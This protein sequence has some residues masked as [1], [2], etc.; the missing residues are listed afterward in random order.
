M[1]SFTSQLRSML[2]KGIMGH[3]I[4]WT[5]K[6]CRFIYNI[7]ISLQWARLEP[8][9]LIIAGT[10]CATRFS[11]IWWKARRKYQIYSWMGYDTDWQG[12]CLGGIL[13]KIT[14]LLDH[15]HFFTL[16]YYSIGVTDQSKTVCARDKDPPPQ[17]KSKLSYLALAFKDNVGNLK[18]YKYIN[19][20]LDYFRLT[21]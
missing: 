9:S 17:R 13:E 10:L 7:N 18:Y 6:H 8:G 11:P 21:Q 20:R 19:K 3:I 15:Y 14:V 5:S 4:P 1:S 2:F 16:F 12:S